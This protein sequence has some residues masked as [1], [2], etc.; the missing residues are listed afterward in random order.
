VRLRTRLGGICGSDLNVITLGAS[1]SLSPFSSFPFVLGHENVAEVLECGAEARA[2]RPGQR[3]VVNP[4]LCCRPRGFDPPCPA[5]AAGHPSRCARVTDG[6]IAPGLLIGTTRGL[7]G[8]WGE[9][10]VAHESQL[11]GVPE[12]VPDEA[13]LLTEPLA[14]SLHAV[15]ATPPAA[16]ERALV[17][18]AGSIGLLTVAALQVVAPAAAV[19]VVA[20]HDFQADHARRLGAGGV[21]RARG[22]HTAALGEAARARM[23]K[24]ILGRAVPVGGFD[25]SYLCIDGTRAADD[26]LRFTRAGGRV[27]FLGNTTALRGMDWSP[28]WAKELTLRGSVCYGV[29]GHGGAGRDAFDEALAVIAAGRADVRPLLTHTFPLAEHRRALSAA[30]DKSRA[31]SVKVAFRF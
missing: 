26:A 6:P 11:V 9:R 25:V 20:R 13:A 18:G 31:R 2:F 29:H 5:C 28:L 7:G 24:P 22:G 4:L 19:T 17:V 14:C 16:G 23:L 30:L 3:V 21:V 15:R 27:V 12:G 1:P 10:F 8:S